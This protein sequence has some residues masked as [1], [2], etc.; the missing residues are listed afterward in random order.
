MTAR[1]ARIRDKTSSKVVLEMVRWWWWWDRS[2]RSRRSL[3]ERWPRSLS[4]SLSRSSLDDG[5]AM[6]RSVVV[7]LVVRVGV[8]VVVARELVSLPYEKVDA[9]SEGATGGARVREEERWDE[10]VTEPC[11]G[12]KS[13]RDSD[14]IRTRALYESKPTRVCN[15]LHQNK[16]CHMTLSPK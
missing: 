14:S 6:A 5:L 10:I 1:I 16:L 3:S 2:V 8:R 7:S 11:G 15:G 9:P 12:R 4:R 13:G